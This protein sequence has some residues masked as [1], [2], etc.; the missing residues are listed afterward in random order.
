MLRYSSPL[1]LV[2]VVGVGHC[3]KGA[4]VL[5]KTCDCDVG[6][7]IAAQLGRLRRGEF[8]FVLVPVEPEV[9]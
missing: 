1:C 5:N 7:D 3:A 9:D 8:D 2:A 4:S 6:S